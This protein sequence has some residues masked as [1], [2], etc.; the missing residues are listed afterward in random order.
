MTPPGLPNSARALTKTEQVRT[1]LREAILNLTLKPGTYLNIDEL[2]RRHGMSPIPIREAVARLES[3]RL[4]VVRPHVGA[5][6]APL[7]EASVH[8]VFALL[9][10]LESA[11]AGRIASLATPQDVV[12]LRELATAMDQPSSKRD[13]EK[14][15][16][17]N[18]AFHLRLAAIA[19]LPLSRD[20]LQAAI[21]HWERIRRHFFPKVPARRQAEAQAEHHAIVDAVERRA[22]AQLEKLLRAHNREARDAYLALLGAGVG[23]RE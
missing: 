8:D 3:E 4:V 7:S 1:T 9:E 14:W 19:A 23:K 15:G 17:A 11:S 18:A 13:Y 6:V 20:H 10:G 21:D 2:A 12:E 22:A 16:H 5:E